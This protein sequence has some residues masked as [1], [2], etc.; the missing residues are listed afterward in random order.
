VVDG[1]QLS[2]IRAALNVQIGS[3]REFGVRGGLIAW[4]EVQSAKVTRSLFLSLT[5]RRLASG[6]RRWVGCTKAG[7]LGRPGT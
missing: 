1:G 6:E 7:D 5:K 3:R 4:A 2:L